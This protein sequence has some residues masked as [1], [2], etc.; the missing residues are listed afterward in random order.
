L[1]VPV[2]VCVMKRAYTLAPGVQ[3][4]AQ[5]PRV[6]SLPVAFHGAAKIRTTLLSRAPI[7]ALLVRHRLSPRANPPP[8]SRSARS[9]KNLSNQF[10][11]IGSI[12]AL[13]SRVGNAR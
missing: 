12:K 1:K 4:A 2:A 3:E 7:L 13:E 8:F 11:G 5:K 9:E 10:S 6:V